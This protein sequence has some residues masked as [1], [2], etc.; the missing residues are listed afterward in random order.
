MPANY[1]DKKYNFTKVDN[2][3]N[4]QEE[5]FM[6][7][8]LET[9]DRSLFEWVDENLNIFS[10]TNKGWKK[11]PVLWVSGERSSYRKKRLLY[12]DNGVVILPAITLE[13][14]EVEKNPSKRSSIFSLIQNIKDEKGGAVTIARRINQEKTSNF[15]TADA[16]RKRG[17]TT[18]QDRNRKRKNK[19]VVYETITVPV[20]MYLE[21]S[22]NI[23]I[24][25][26]Y[27]QQMNEI[28]LPFINQP[29]ADNYFLLKKDGHTF[30]AFVDPVY[31]IENNVS[32]LQDELRSYQTNISIRVL[33][34]TIGAD[35]NDAQPKI[36]KRENAVEVK[37]G[38]ERVIV[39][40]SPELTE[41][42]FYK[43]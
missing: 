3:E 43:P 11:V 18:T 29:G 21:I 33:G 25:S 37:M 34:Y 1:R 12:D 7:S 14:G 35:K 30:E 38:R 24:Q 27:Q 36:V 17:F 31:S 16:F 10:T 26:E 28:L 2:P 13:R 19:K 32:N 41:D 40:D 23:M 22:Y 9:I 42:G 8:T 39:G 6:P 5:I 15:A 4:V 20:P